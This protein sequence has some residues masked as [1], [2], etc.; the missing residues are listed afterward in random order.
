MFSTDT[1]QDDLYWG[2]FPMKFAS[3][4][5]E[6]LLQQGYLSDCLQ[7]SFNDNTSVIDLNFICTLSEKI[8]NYFSSFSLII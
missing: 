6:A 4:S 1:S 7:F 3:K 8:G 2:S 5:Y